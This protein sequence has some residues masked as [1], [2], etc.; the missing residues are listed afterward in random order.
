MKAICATC[1][2]DLTVV[3][4]EYDGKDILLPLVSVSILP[5]C[6]CMSRAASEAADER[7]KDD[8]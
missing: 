5:C 4:E 6:N 3:D 2:G 8:A 7:G 1:G